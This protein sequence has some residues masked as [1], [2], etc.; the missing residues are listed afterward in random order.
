M[1]KRERQLDGLTARGAALVSCH[2][3]KLLCRQPSEYGRG[4]ALCPRC[5]AKLHARKPESLKRTWALVLA[6]AILYI[7][8]NVLPITLTSSF[9]ATQADTIL[10]GVIYFMNTGSWHLAIIIFV[11]SIV[12]PLLK[13]LVLSYLLL[14]VHIRSLWRP[15]DRTRL[16]RLI[17]AVGRWSMLDIFAVTVVVA[18]VRMGALG[19]IQ[20]GPGAPFFGAVVVTTMLATHFFDP[21]LIWDVV[22]EAR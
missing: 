16:Y 17:E 11:A 2:S 21:R 19:T 10:S 15:A 12:V 6:A 8:A 1:A 9:G 4:K 3:C 22:E 5:G 7:P 13:L 14:S 20:A 18:L